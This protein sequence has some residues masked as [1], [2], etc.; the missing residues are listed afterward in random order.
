ML[1]RHPTRGYYQASV[2]HASDLLNAWIGVTG[3]RERSMAFPAL[4]VTRGT[5]SQQR[6]TRNDRVAQPVMRPEGACT[7]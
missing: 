7:P 6:K 2:E 3:Y 5:A 4:G 1:Y